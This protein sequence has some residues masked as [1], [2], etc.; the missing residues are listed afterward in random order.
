MFTNYLTPRG[1]FKYRLSIADSNAINLSLAIFTTSSKSFGTSLAGIFQPFT[2]ILAFATLSSSA[3]TYKHKPIKI[4][5]Q[6][7]NNLLVREGISLLF[8]PQMDAMHLVHQVWGHHNLK[9]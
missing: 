2:C 9:S 1:G 6:I 4:Y 8:V 5:L 7:R 3:S